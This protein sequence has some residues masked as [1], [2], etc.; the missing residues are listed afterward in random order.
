MFVRLPDQTSP[1]E[2]SL[3]VDGRRL[4]LMRS[5]VWTH[6]SEQR[7]LRIEPGTVLRPPPSEVDRMRASA[8]EAPADADIEQL[9]ILGYMQGPACEALDPPSDEEPED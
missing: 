7:N 4:D 9:C 6:S 3:Q 2:A 8:G 5:G 1:D